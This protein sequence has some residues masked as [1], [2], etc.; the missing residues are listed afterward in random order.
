MLAC[1]QPVS[2]FRR[3]RSLLS[4]RSSHLFSTA[5]PLFWEAPETLTMAMHVCLL[6]VLPQCMLLCP[7]QSS[8]ACPYERDIRVGIGGKRGDISLKARGLLGCLHARDRP[9]ALPPTAPPSAWSM[10]PQKALPAVTPART[11]LCKL[12]ETRRWIL[13]MLRIDVPLSCA[14]VRQ[15]PAWGP[16]QL[17]AQ[18]G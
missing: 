1:S 5:S 17:S 7:F 12:M 15:P 8:S 6:L 4:K 13:G 2:A 16:E 11:Q 18:D 9:A 10:P 3:R 14:A